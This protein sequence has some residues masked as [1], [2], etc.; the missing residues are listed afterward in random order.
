MSTTAA[1]QPKDKSAPKD[2]KKEFAAKADAYARRGYE[3][4][5]STS[6]AD[7]GREYYDH[8]RKNGGSVSADKDKEIR[9]SMNTI[10]THELKLWKQFNEVW[11][12]NT[13]LL[14]DREKTSMKALVNEITTSEEAEKI[15]KAEL[16]LIKDSK[17]TIDSKLPGAQYY[18]HFAGRLQ[19]SY[20]KGVKDD[21]HEWWAV[22]NVLDQS[23]KKESSTAAPNG[24][25]TTETKDAAVDPVK[26]RTDSTDNKAGEQ[27]P[28]AAAP[29]QTTEKAAE[30][31]PLTPPTVSTE[32]AAPSQ[33]S[34]EALK[35]Q[36]DS[37]AAATTEKAAPTQA[38]VEAPK[39]QTE[40]K[41]PAAPE[42]AAAAPTTESQAPAPDSKT[43]SNGEGS[44]A[45][46]TKQ[47]TS[48]AAAGGD[49]SG[50]FDEAFLAR[51]SDDS[52]PAPKDKDS[53]QQTNA[54]G[55]GTASTTA[56]T[57][58]KTE[59]QTAEATK[60]NG[61]ESV[62]QAN[63]E[64]SAATASTQTDSATTKAAE[65]AATDSESAKTTNK[66]ATPIESATTE[67]ATK[68]SNVETSAASVGTD[69]P[70]RTRVKD[71]TPP[72]PPAG[73][74]VAR[75]GD[76]G[77]V[78]FKKD[79]KIRRAGRRVSRALNFGGSNSEEQAEVEESGTETSVQAEAPA[80][81]PTNVLRTDAKDKA[82]PP[83]PPIEFGNFSPKGIFTRHPDD[84]VVRDTLSSR[85]AEKIGNILGVRIG[86]KAS[87]EEER[88]Q[89][90]A[91]SERLETIRRG[92]EEATRS[93]SSPEVATVEPLK[94]SGETTT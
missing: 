31:Q 93:K 71:N 64:G 39:P 41:E 70:I 74:S 19:E 79:T 25:A 89:A 13:S 45:E 29:A 10:E 18:D 8:V 38:P 2:E 28:A 77:E 66:G 63:T 36:T 11:I 57:P 16:L 54:A 46:T 32:S 43:K 69:T 40:S 92:D 87:R 5:K 47:P 90:Q 72:R 55:V 12:D 94:T 21:N 48:T 67:P 26:A 6:Y 42:K 62:K 83:I 73:F 65:P 68:E 33:A 1:A 61:S 24:G 80:T 53:T 86:A 23:A 81:A 27:K 14:N 76:N 84:H 35:P 15:W 60:P 44:G 9:N 59:P 3:R 7:R 56:S 4:Y 51:G 37:K 34:T 17:P 75:S 30:P 82:I 58:E 49:L 85:V 91:V 78:T 88:A 22:F 20:D 52:A 50:R